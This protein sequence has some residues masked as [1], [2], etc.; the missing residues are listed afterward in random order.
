[1]S[2]EEMSLEELLAREEIHVLLATYNVAGDRGRLDELSGVFAPDGIMVRAESE[3]LKGPAAIARA[4][5]LTRVLKGTGKPLTFVR[6]N[7][8]TSLVAF[9]GDDVAHGR[10]YFLGVTDIG[11]D[12]CGVYIDDFKNVDGK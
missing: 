10:I 6:H 9:D 4:L 3:K 11:P 8:T 2:L 7:L 12:H 5:G 1:M